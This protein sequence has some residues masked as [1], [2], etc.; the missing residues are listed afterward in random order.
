MSILS[1]LCF[2]IITPY[3][4]ETQQILPTAF[5]LPFYL[6]LLNTFR[7][8]QQGRYFYLHVSAYGHDTTWPGPM[9]PLNPI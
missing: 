5:I 2:V 3:A 8:A 7:P 1:P 6:C 9:Y 4:Q